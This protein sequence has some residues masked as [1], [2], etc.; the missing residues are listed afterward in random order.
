MVESV[1][2]CTRCGSRSE[3]ITT[4]LEVVDG[5]MKEACPQLHLCTFC[6]DSLGRWMDRKKS[7]RHRSSGRSQSSRSEESPSKR[8]DLRLS[9]S[10][11]DSPSTE[12]RDEEDDDFGEPRGRSLDD[13]FFPKSKRTKHEQPLTIRTVLT[14]PAFLYACLFV[15][16]LVLVFV[17]LQTLKTGPVEPVLPVESAP[18]N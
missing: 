5:A 4:S 11:D 3:P 10:P 9:S 16:A 15:M 8:P 17:L 2:A 7:H 6:T 14:H 1:R 13:S 12:P 18:E